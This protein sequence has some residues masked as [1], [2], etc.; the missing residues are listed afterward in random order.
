MTISTGI[1]SYMSI[2]IY[3]YL[4]IYIYTY[5]YIYIFFPTSPLKR[6]GCSGSNLPLA[7]L[8]LRRSVRS[9]SGLSCG[10]LLLRENLLGFGN[11][12]SLLLLLLLVEILLPLLI[13][14][15]LSLPLLLRGLGT[16]MLGRLVVLLPLPAHVQKGART[17]NTVTPLNLDVYKTN[18]Y[19]YII[20]YQY[21][22]IHI[23]LCAT[24]NIFEVGW[25]WQ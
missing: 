8:G 4:H 6:L 20:I 12:G 19:I 21:I 25:T 5:L 1:F 2:S 16:W 7:T 11:L 15:L 13:L 17:C 14:S 22:Y 23:L 10:L 18:I 3:T 9:L 24:H